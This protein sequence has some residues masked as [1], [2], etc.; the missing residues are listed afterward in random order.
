[1]NDKWRRKPSEERK[2]LVFI[3][4]KIFT[5]PNAFGKKNNSNIICFDLEKKSGLHNLCPSLLDTEFSKIRNK[6]YRK[7][8]LHEKCNFMVNNLKES[9]EWNTI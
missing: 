1:M 2:L 6:T 4:K 3:Q 8:G 7:V 5:N 9:L